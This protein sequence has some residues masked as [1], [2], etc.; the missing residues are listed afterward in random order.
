MEGHKYN[1]SVDVYSFGVVLCELTSRILPFSDTYKRFDFI[2]A[3][4]EEGAMPT[5]PRWCDAMPPVLE[6]DDEEGALFGGTGAPTLPWGWREDAPHMQGLLLRQQAESFQRR[7][8][9]G[10]ASS[11]AH[12]AAAASGMQPPDPLVGG[13]DDVRAAAAGV[14]D[15]VAAAVS[16][17]EAAFGA[18][19]APAGSHRSGSRDTTG[20]ASAS[21]LGGVGEWRIAGGECN[22]V[23]RAAIEACLDRDPDRRPTFRDLVELLHALLDRPASDLFMQL[24][25]P[26]LRE[27][28]AY[29]DDTVAAVAANE[30]V[31]FASLALFASIPT[32][33]VPGAARPVVNPQG[34]GSAEE[35]GGD[36]EPPAGLAAARGSFRAASASQAAAASA[37]PPLLRHFMPRS[38]GFYPLLPFMPAPSLTMSQASDAGWDGRMGR[39]RVVQSRLRSVLQMSG[40][41]YVGLETVVDAGPELLAGLAARLRTVD[42]GIRARLGLPLF[43]PDLG[44]AMRHGPDSTLI[45]V[46][47]GERYGVHVSGFVRRQA[48][49]TAAPSPAPELALPS[50]GGEPLQQQQQPPLQRP[51]L[52]PGPSSSV[53]PHLKHRAGAAA[54]SAASKAAAKAAAARAAE[55]RLARRGAVSASSHCLHSLSVLLQVRPFARCVRINAEPPPAAASPPPPL[56]L[57]PTGAGRSHPCPY[58]R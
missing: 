47:D 28:L 13:V 27:A 14:L 39:P 2:D 6:A 10:R 45:L 35:D 29:G 9:G 50:Q 3:V 33:P 32:L 4:L 23:L 48:A 1:G 31:H 57:T 46:R 44:E 8:D 18:G 7:T 15:S 58:G 54:S 42:L 40:V 56:T 26:R 55:E 17:A 16:V 53:P 37:T 11:S 43:C 5:I 41:P 22:G 49:P 36:I 38:T 34:G 30:I 52:G 24:E 21:V 20:P 12:V 25:L 51:S 19:H